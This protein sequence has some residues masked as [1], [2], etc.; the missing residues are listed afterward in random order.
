LDFTLLL[1]PMTVLVAAQLC[2]RCFRTL[3]RY[4]HGERSHQRAAT[5]VLL[6]NLVKLLALRRQV[7]CFPNKIVKALPSDQNLVDCLVQNNLKMKLQWRQQWHETTVR[8]REERTPTDQV[9]K[10]FVI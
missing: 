4:T 10:Q 7:L 8:K 9:Q 2:A 1:A 6:R 3:A 5:V